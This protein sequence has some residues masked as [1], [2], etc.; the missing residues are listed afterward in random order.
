M[1][2]LAKTAITAALVASLS[3][4]IVIGGGDSKGSISYDSD[5]KKLQTK[6]AEYIAGLELSENIDS[7][8]TDLGLPSLSEAFV[9]DGKEVRV[10]YYRTQHVK[11]DGKTTVDETTPLVF[12]DGQLKGWGE[13]ALGQ[14]R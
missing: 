13:S 10:L 7:V 8:I 3:G 12:V 2:L 9:E 11:S 4:C 14:I 5:W 6:N 1:H